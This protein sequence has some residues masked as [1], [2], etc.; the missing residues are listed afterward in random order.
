V[1]ALSAVVLIVSYCFSTFAGVSLNTFGDLP[2]DSFWKTGTRMPTP[3]SETAS[4]LL[5]DKI[6]IMG[7]LDETDRPLDIVEV[8]DVKLDKWST[9]ASLPIPLDHSG[10]DV[11]NQKIYLVGGKGIDSKTSDRLFIYDPITDKWEEGKSM[12]TARYALTVDFIDGILFAMGGKNKEL[13]GYA[14]ETLSTNEAYDPAINKWITKASL[15]TGRH[16]AASAVVDGKLYVIGGRNTNFLQ[17]LY[18]DDNEMYDIKTDTW[19]K[20]ESMPTNRSASDT[21]VIDHGIHVFGGEICDE[22]GMSNKVFDEHELYNTELNKWTQ[23][24]KMP[25]ARHGPSVQFVDR[26]I[27]VIG[28]G[29]QPCTS[30]SPLNEILVL[31]SSPN[32]TNNNK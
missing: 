11:L 27:Y 8:Y 32:G 15:P 13:M 9:A 23:E 21:A 4:V 31:P 29:V 10:A 3:R 30:Q 24:L 1:L 18:L 22:G 20:L 14:R 17:R 12:P 28:G 5:G 7:G 2:P 19:Q 25:T 16:H 26:Y 6:Y